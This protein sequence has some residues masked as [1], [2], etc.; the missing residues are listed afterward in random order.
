MLNAFMKDTTNLR[1]FIF[2]FPLLPFGA[3]RNR[4]WQPQPTLQHI[5]KPTRANAQTKGLQ[6][7]CNFANALVRIMK[8]LYI[9]TE[10]SKLKRQ[11]ENIWRVHSENQ[12]RKGFTA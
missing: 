4:Q 7:S 3:I 9:W 11:D 12:G 5:C 6:K 8:I 1:E 2:S 10:S